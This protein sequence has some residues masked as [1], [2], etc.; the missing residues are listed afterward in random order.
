MT[1]RALLYKS[2]LWRKADTSAKGWDTLMHA[3]AASGR[4]CSTYQAPKNVRYE[5][6]CA[7]GIPIET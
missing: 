1:E 5:S 3:L 6:F 2:K 7:L 4:R